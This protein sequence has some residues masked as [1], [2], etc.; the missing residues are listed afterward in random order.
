MPR[1]FPDGFR[2][3]TAT[4]AHQIEGGNVNN[5]WWAFEHTEGSGCREPSGDACDSWHRWPEDVALC[6]ELGL[7]DYR[8][9]VEW[10]RIEP[11]EGMWSTV[12]VD[13]YRR[14]CEALLAAGIDP[15]VTFHHFTTPRW[16]AARGGWT[17]PATADRFAAFCR[18]LAGELAPVLRRAC[19]INEPSMVSTLGH[20]AG[21]FPPGRQ[22]SDLRRTVN[23]VFCAA[24][25]QAVDAIRAAAPGVPVGITLAMS[26]Y[27]AVG[28]PAAEA[29]LER[30]RYRMEDEFFEATEGDDF[31]GVQTYSRTRVGD[32]DVL[33][34][35][36]GVDTL[37][38]GYEFYPEALAATIRRAWTLTSGEVPV[39]VTEN[40]IGTTDDEQRIRYVR[41][42]LEG[43][44]DCIDDGIDVRGYTY[45][46]L[47]DN[48]EWAHGYGPQFGMVACDR[49]T[50][51]RAPKASA[52]WLGSIARANALPDA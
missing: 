41:T 2:W 21:V 49:T 40:G 35:E 5:D 44:L 34:P 10:S 51:E 25:R 47:L 7:T 8:F 15:V 42:A 38:M 48:F 17:D 30:I 6:A 20:L 26:D 3:G 45:W 37:V 33:G 27:Q 52:R 28:G 14:Q 18:R 43:V 22:D 39:L 11:E 36:D 24:H 13:R 23:A 4:A 12:A 1:A 9:S 16:V 31:V 46:S 19:T 32:D 50:F 29:R